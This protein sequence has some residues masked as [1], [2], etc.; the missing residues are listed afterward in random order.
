MFSIRTAAR[1]TAAT[2]VTAAAMNGA[3]GAA[4]AQDVDVNVMAQ[5]IMS[6]MYNKAT[7]YSYSIEKDGQF[8]KSGA[9]GLANTDYPGTDMTAYHKIE[10]ASATKNFTAVAILRNLSALG[11][12]PDSKVL[13]YI[14]PGWAVGD[15]FEDVTFRHLLTHTSGI[16][17]R[18]LTFSD[19]DK[20]KWTTL[21]DG[22]KFMVSKGTT[23]GQASSY[24]NMNYAL[25]RTI[26]PRL[27]NQTASGSS[28]NVNLSPY[29]SG[30]E[31]LR[32]VNKMLAVAGINPTHCSNAKNG[33][34]TEA[35]NFVNWQ[36]GGSY[37]SLQGDDAQAC[38][39]HRGLHLSAREMARFARYT[40]TSSSMLS[41]SARSLMDSGKLGWQQQSNTGSRT[42]FYWHGGDITVGGNRQLH[43][44]IMK[45]PD[46]VQAAII[47]NSE[48]LAGD[49][50]FVLRKAY[51]DAT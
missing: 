44:C 17:Q 28:E 2:I 12:S 22:V 4:Q 24:T 11:K 33:S 46:N 40:A 35:H 27:W 34:E 15:G 48:N 23:A 25:L 18:M 3:A 49:T 13:P 16:E 30:T 21:T 29:A 1:L 6:T 19:A 9:G 45:L 10:I 7:G 31:S 42:G 26:L 38:A 20:A 8:A 39:G 51:D 47:V 5:S 36:I 50:C 41:A 43:T 37:V 14:P 32:Y